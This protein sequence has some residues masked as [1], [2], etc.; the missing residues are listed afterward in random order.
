MSVYISFTLKT[1]TLKVRS[2]LTF[3]WLAENHRFN[4]I[5]VLQEFRKAYSH[6]RKGK[7]VEEGCRCGDDCSAA[8]RCRKLCG[9][10]FAAG[11]PGHPWRILM[12]IGTQRNGSKSASAMC[13]ADVLTCTS[14]CG[15]E[16]VVIQ[17]HW[18]L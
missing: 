13:C 2:G 15:F 9:R 16:Y 17:M 8:G 3:P 7:S 11:H 4:P 12:T 6:L 18:Q 5:L 10:S 14:A 1:Q